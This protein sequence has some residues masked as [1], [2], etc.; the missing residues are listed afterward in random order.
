M[1]IECILVFGQIKVQLMIKRWNFK[2]LFT[3][4]KYSYLERLGLEEVKNILM[5]YYKELNKI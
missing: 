3:I 2:K 1:Q 5:V 4:K